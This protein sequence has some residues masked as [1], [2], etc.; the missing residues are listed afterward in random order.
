MK[1]LGGVETT[2]ESRII[3]FHIGRLSSQKKNEAVMLEISLEKS[4]ILRGYYR[5]NNL[6]LL[7]EKLERLLERLGK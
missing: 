4:K 6:H 7:A 3:G 1:A 5:E 2:N